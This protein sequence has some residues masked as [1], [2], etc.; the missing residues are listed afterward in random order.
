MFKYVNLDENEIFEV[1]PNLNEEIQYDL[2]ITLYNNK[3][4]FEPII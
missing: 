4:N 2:E 1:D 3:K